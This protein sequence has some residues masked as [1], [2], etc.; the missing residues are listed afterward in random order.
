[1]AH[2]FVRLLREA[3]RVPLSWF[4]GIQLRRW[5]CVSYVLDRQPEE[6]TYRSNKRVR[7]PSEAGIVPLSAAKPSSL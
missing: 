1:M 7:L 2:R 6:H 5:D 3:G 4:Q